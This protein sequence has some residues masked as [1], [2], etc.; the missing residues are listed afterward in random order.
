MASIH[1]AEL[2]IH[3]MALSK[4]SLTF[5]NPGFQRLESL[6]ACL[7]AVKAWMDIFLKFPPIEYARLSFTFWVQLMRSIV[8]LYKLSTW[9]DPAWDRQIVRDTIDLVDVMEQITRNMEWLGGQI[10]ESADDDM[11]VRAAKFLRCIQAGCYSG[12]GADPRIPPLDE[13]QM[14]Q[15]PML[16]DYPDSVWLRD[17]FS[18]SGFQN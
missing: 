9:D 6:C 17:I 5:D 1:Y 13:S 18:F 14:L 15:D 8:V 16:F 12:V 3:E 7:A 2:S 11:I 4:A 10:G